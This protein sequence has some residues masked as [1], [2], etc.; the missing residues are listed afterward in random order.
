MFIF[1]LGAVCLLQK[2]SF[3]SENHGIAGDKL[4]LSGFSMVSFG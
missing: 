3:F 4:C 1:K 2:Y